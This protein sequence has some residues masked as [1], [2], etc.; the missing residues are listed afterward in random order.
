MTLYYSVDRRRLFRQGETLELIKQDLS[1]FPM[2]S[3]CEEQ[4]SAGISPHG[5]TYFLG[6]GIHFSNPTNR[7]DAAIEYALELL[8]QQRYP[9][10]P[11][12]FTSMFGCETLDEA[13]HF[14]GASNSTLNTPIYEVHSDLICHKGDMNL[15][16]PGCAL[17]EFDR[18]LN[19]YWQGKTYSLRDGYE[20]FWEVVIPLPATISQ[21]VS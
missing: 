1:K 19:A 18:R 13:K 17:H 6:H 21:M 14:R 11:S 10:K 2:T 8:R 16:S 20:P 5:F 9:E 7:A 3:Q 4:F 12:R 15:F